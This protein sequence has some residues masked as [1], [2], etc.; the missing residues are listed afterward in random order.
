MARKK[1]TTNTE[2]IKMAEIVEVKEV[3]K[4]EK[5][6]KPR[7]STKKSDSTEPKKKTTKKKEV[8]EKAVVDIKEEVKNIQHNDIIISNTTMSS[9]EKATDKPYTLL[10]K[11]IKIY[12][13]ASNNS[14]VIFEDKCVSVDGKK[15]PYNR[16][17]IINK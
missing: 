7:K 5:P 14:V 2:D 1:K 6:K 16:L 15:Y 9:F 13:S 11:G 3:V 17:R 12:D 10:Y 8:A 4:E